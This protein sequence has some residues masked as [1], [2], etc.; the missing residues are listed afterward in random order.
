[1]ADS[2]APIPVVVC[3]KAE[4]VGKPV[5]EGLKP[6][7]EVV[8]FC[9][10]AQ[11][12]AAEVPYIL[13]GVAPPTQSS[14]VGTGNYSSPPVAV[15]MGAAWDEADVALVKAAIRR[16]AEAG[17]TATAAPVILRNDTSVP[18]PQ[19]PAPGYAEQLIRRMRL[20]LGKLVR[21][22]KLDGPEEGIVWY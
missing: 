9:L 2:S 21:G 11:S 14:Q 5:A 13:Q 8:L 17:G 1:M 22:E 10:G 4:I 7:Y 16:S 12:T 19:P 6:E 18:A 3:G 20:A 15:I